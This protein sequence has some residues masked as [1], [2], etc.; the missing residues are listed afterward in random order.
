MLLLSYHFPP[1]PGVGGQRWEEFVRPVTERGWRVDVVTLDPSR[2]GGAEWDRVER[3][4]PGL[5]LYGASPT[6][7]LSARA[8]RFVSRAYAWLRNAIGGASIPGHGGSSASEGG[9]LPGLEGVDVDELGA[10]FTGGRATLRAAWAWIQYRRD[11]AWVQSCIDVAGQLTRR[12]R[13]RVVVTSGP[14]HLTHEAGRQVGRT[15]EVP[16]VLDYRDPWAVAEVLPEHLASPVWRSLAQRHERRCVEEAV[17]VVANTELLRKRM[18]EEY[19]AAADRTVTVLNGFA[20][21]RVERTPTRDR[22]VIAYA[23]SIYLD[24]DPRYLFRGVSAVVDELSLSPDD[25]EVA[26]MGRTEDWGEGLRRMAAEE[27]IGEHLTLH[28]EGSRREARDF[29]RGA[30]LLVS[31][32][33]SAEMAIPSKLYTYMELDAWILAQARA[34]SATERLLRDTDADVVD[35]ADRPGTAAI[36]EKRY[37]EFERGDRPVPLASSEPGLASRRQATLLLDQIERRIP[38]EPGSSPR[39]RGHRR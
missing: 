20:E 37:L 27:G 1:G 23:G 7:P 22:F 11:R 15:G 32:P 26:F 3:L 24:R 21:R 17:L 2:V 38:A 4:P 13:Y 9:T 35:P 5:R 33:Q 8:E 6:K 30:A 39:G 19:P 18:A 16:L 25:L 36:V 14:P 28:S 31:L 10:P 12:R 34:G 29:L